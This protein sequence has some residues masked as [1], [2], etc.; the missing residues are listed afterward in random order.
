LHFVSM[1]LYI[2]T[3]TM[4]IILTRMIRRFESCTC[5][6]HFVF[7]HR[8]FPSSFFDSSWFLFVFFYL[9]IH[10]LRLKSTSDIIEKNALA[11]SFFFLSFFFF[12]SFF[13]FF[14]FFFFLCLFLFS[15]HFLLNYVYL[16]WTLLILSFSSSFF[17]LFYFHI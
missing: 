13:S 9:C 6:G 2:H 8:F 16:C 17:A 5:N 15:F 7:R 4:I 10:S 1:R 14:I 3:H 11:F 12:S